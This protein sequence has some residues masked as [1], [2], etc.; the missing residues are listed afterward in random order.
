MTDPG[1]TLSGEALATLRHDL[2]TPV[3][4]IMGYAEMLLEDLDAA[5]RAESRRGIEE[6]LGAARDVL[7]LIND[8]L[9]PSR[10]DVEEAA[11][12][13]LYDSLREPQQRII[14]QVRALLGRSDDTPIPTFEQD[15]R[16]IMRAAER[17]VPKEH[18]ART[19]AEAGA[20]AEAGEARAE[21]TA[22]APSAP[23]VP[24]ILVVDD[25][26]TNRDVLR[27]RLEREGYDVALAAHGREAL[28]RVATG[29]FDLVL[30]DVMMPEVDGYQVLER[31]KQAPATRDI[32]VIVIS[33]LD[34]LKSIV[35]CIEAGAEDYLPKPFDPV[36][37]RA[38]IGASLEK[39]R[40]RDQEVEYLRQVDR[41]IEAAMAVEAGTYRA[42]TLER[43][44][45]RRDALG[46]LARAFDGMAA[47]VRAREHRL[48]EQ[49]RE[50]QG[51]IAEARLS[52]T[53]SAARAD[54]RELQPGDSFA[55]RYEIV[56]VVGSGGMG[57]VYHARD[58][59]LDDV[60][61]IKTLRSEFVSDLTVIERFKG[62][63]RLTR[64]LSH[65]NVVRTHDFGE[66]S[67]MYYITME[68]V[69]GMTV[70]EL[71]DTRDRLG[72]ASTLAIGRQLADSL[73]AAHEQG[74]IHRDIKPQNLLLDADGVLKVMDFG[75]ARLAQRA[76]KLTEAGLV[77]GTPY[78]MSPEQLLSEEV[79][80]RTDLYAAG[81]VLFECLTG[82]LPF[83]ASNAVALIAKVLDQDPPEPIA[84]SPEV[85]PAL[86]Q[87]VIQLLAKHPDDRL[88]TATELA[89]RLGQ[90]S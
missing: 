80:P 54:E 83:E 42:G 51:E 7:T 26:E 5:G 27:R 22:A 64:R 28:E 11:L 43:I 71:I 19:P 81:V 23:V 41:V 88:Q 50:L 4:H 56:A 82:T 33:A 72:V 10:A 76:S 53:A 16:K 32:P 17:L 73:A 67:G 52:G 48:Q 36:L 68:Y 86:S 18:E 78:Y 14:G 57:T 38:R 34:D 35:R 90:M 59:E 9:G 47:Q 84:L 21:A 66:W 6:T 60:V 61:A 69:E 85:P 1:R 37:L 20:A 70:R 49:V 3:N 87:L 30:L 40:L 2:R 58:L 65:H 15:L 79:D 12:R 24:Q 77:V 74:V 31:L 25:E 62:E 29:G 44:T 39:K 55:D 8:T 89:A 63:L 45:E 75:V 46:H 13:V